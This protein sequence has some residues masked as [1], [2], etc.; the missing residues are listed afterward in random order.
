[1]A[2]DLRRELSDRLAEAE[3]TLAADMTRL[4]M[5]HGRE[6]A[7]QRLSAMCDLRPPVVAPSEAGNQND[8]G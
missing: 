5:P 2:E 1:M 8:A 3:R 7:W 6:A 4:L